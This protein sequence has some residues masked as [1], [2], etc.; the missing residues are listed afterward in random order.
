VNIQT[1]TSQQKDAKSPLRII[2]KNHPENQIIGDINE[3]V[4]TRRKLI[5]DTEQSHVAFLS[6]IEPTNFEEASKEEEWIRA[7]NEE[8]DQIEKNNTWKLV[9]RPENKNVIGSKWVFKNK[10]NEKGQVVRNKARLVCK[11]Y[12]QVEGQDFDE[13][14]APVARLEAIIMFLA[15]SCHKNFKVYQMDVKSTFLNGDLQEEV[16]M[17]QPEGFLLTDNPNYVC[18]LKKALYGLK[19]APRAWY[20]RLDKFLQE[21]GFKKGTVDINLYIKSE[22]DDLLV[23]LVYVDDLF[24]VVLMNHLSSGLL[25]LCK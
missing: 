16:Y 8:L 7:M 4:Q 21:K 1:D 5:K 24:L 19:Q 15:Y 12:A 3:G 2:S 22:G 13:T 20:S 6:M 18:K 10:M 11:R 9:P 25:I 23:V 14:F 17:E